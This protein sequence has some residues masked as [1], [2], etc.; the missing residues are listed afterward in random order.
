[1]K[2]ITY[3]SGDPDN[4]LDLTSFQLFLCKLAQICDTMKGGDTITALVA[5]KAANGPAY[6]FASN[7]RKDMELEH[8]KNFL[9]DL[10][11]FIGKNPNRLAD[12]PLRKQVLWRILEF[13]FPRVDYYLKR[14]LT[15]IGECIDTWHPH[16]THKSKRF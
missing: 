6:L 11:G 13:N 15:S 3:T 10:L 8:T 1:M 12:K 7:N 5:Q 4:Y 16:I 2:N 9:S 14:I